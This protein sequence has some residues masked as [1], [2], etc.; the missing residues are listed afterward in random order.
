MPVLDRFLGLL[1]VPAYALQRGKL[2]PLRLLVIV[3]LASFLGTA[4]A[5]V[6]MLQDGV[7]LSLLVLASVS[8][9]TTAALLWAHLRRYL[10]FRAV[11]PL[12]EPAPDLRAEEKVLFH[13]SGS[14]EVNG[15]RRYLVEAP[16]VFWTTRLSEHIVC[17]KVQAPNFLGI[18]VPTA[19]RGWWYA[20]LVPRHITKITPGQLCFGV[21]CRHAVRV[22]YVSG[23]TK[24]S[25]YLTCDDHSQMALLLKELRAKAGM[26]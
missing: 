11:A 1:C 4:Y 21:Q 9:L 7:R 6:R 8:L 19:E 26:H 22:A 13:A 15:M 20:F 25:L 12:P 17:A 18:G 24:D 10:V 16:A 3:V 14:F 2:G 23:K 5:V